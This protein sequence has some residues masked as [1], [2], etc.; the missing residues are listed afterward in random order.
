MG[1]WADGESSVHPKRSNGFVP[2]LLGG[3][4][5]THCLGPSLEKVQP[6]RLAP[7]GQQQPEAPPADAGAQ[8]PLDLPFWE[9]WG[10]PGVR[11]RMLKQLPRIL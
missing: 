9:G 4:P 11:R 8:C 10:F 2:A 1:L 6:H 7:P 3:T 5:G